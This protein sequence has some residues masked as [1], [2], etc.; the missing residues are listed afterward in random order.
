MLALCS[1]GSSSPLTLVV[2]KLRVS[3]PRGLG[4]TSG[5]PPGNSPGHSVEAL[6]APRLDETCPA[7]VSVSF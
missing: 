3:D 4:E 7:L 2:F 5:E 1:S 6:L